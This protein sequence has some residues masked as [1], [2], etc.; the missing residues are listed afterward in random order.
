MILEKLR[1]LTV[2]QYRKLLSAGID[3]NEET[4]VQ[5]ALK[6]MRTHEAIDLINYDA[7]M[8]C[9]INAKGYYIAEVLWYGEKETGTVEW[10]SWKSNPVH[11]WEFAESLALDYMLGLEITIFDDKTI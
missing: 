1:T 10:Q 5:E 7:P 6:F 3:V 11:D 4:T 2:K 9:N 8:Y